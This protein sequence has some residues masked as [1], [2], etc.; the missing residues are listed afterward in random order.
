VNTKVHTIVLRACGLSREQVLAI[1][2]NTSPQITRVGNTS[3]QEERKDEVRSDEGDG[4]GGKKK[5]L[6]WREEKRLGFRAACLR[7]WLLDAARVQGMRYPRPLSP[8]PNDTA[9]SVVPDCG[10]RNVN[11]SF[12]LVASHDPNSR[13]TGVGFSYG[14]D[15]DRS[16]VEPQLWSSVMALG[17]VVAS[18]ES[19]MPLPRGMRNTNHIAGNESASDHRGWHTKRPSEGLEMNDKMR[20]DGGTLRQESLD[21][22]AVETDEAQSPIRQTSLA[23]RGRASKT[24]RRSASK[25]TLSP[26]TRSR[27]SCDRGIKETSISETRASLKRYHS[28]ESLL[29]AG[30]EDGE[31]RHDVFENQ[32]G[33]PVRSRKSETDISV[34]LG[35]PSRHEGGKGEDGSP[36]QIVAGDDARAEGQDQRARGQTIHALCGGDNTL[37]RA[38]DLE[39]AAEEGRRLGLLA[40]ATCLDMDKKEA[41]LSRES[42][43]LRQ[44]REDFGERTQADVSSLEVLLANARDLRKAAGDSVRRLEPIAR[45]ARN[46]ERAVEVELR[47]QQK[48]TETTTYSFVD[49]VELE[50]DLQER[51]DHAE[52]MKNE[53]RGAR[54]GLEAAERRIDE[55]EAEE[56]GLRS[57]LS[58][59]DTMFR[60]TTADISSAM[61]VVVAK[62]NALRRTE[63]T[64]V[65][66]AS[67]LR[68]LAEIARDE[69]TLRAVVP[70]GSD[71]RDLDLQ[72]AEAVHITSETAREVEETRLRRD[73]A[74]VAL[75]KARLNLSG[76]D[77]MGHGIV[78]PGSN[79]AATRARTAPSVRSTADNTRLH[80]N[81]SYDDLS[82]SSEQAP[83]VTEGAPGLRGDV[84]R[85]G[86]SVHIPNVTGDGG[87]DPNGGGAKNGDGRQE[88]ARRA[89]AE[90]GETQSG[91]WEEGAGTEGVISLHADEAMVGADPTS[92]ATGDK[93]PNDKI[94]TNA[95]AH[96]KSPMEAEKVQRLS[97]AYS[98]ATQEYM[99]AVARRESPHVKRALALIRDHGDII[100]LKKKSTPEADIHRD[101]LVQ[102]RPRSKRRPRGETPLLGVQLND[103]IALGAEIAMLRGSGEE[104]E[105][106]NRILPEIDDRFLTVGQRLR[107]L[108]DARDS[109]QREKDRAHMKYSRQVKRNLRERKRFVLAEKRAG[110]IAKTMDTK[111][112]VEA[113]K[114]RGYETE[115]SEQLDQLR[116]VYVEGIQPEIRVRLHATSR[117]TNSRNKHRER[118]DTVEVGEI[119]ARRQQLTSS[120]RVTPYS[121]SPF[122]RLNVRHAATV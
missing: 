29:S 84:C 105:E 104:D 69:E 59:Y 95:F 60:K 6:P 61:A 75:E 91:R 83:A 18:C 48:K 93:I 38:A 24:Q 111:Q 34:L 37:I 120:K 14:E 89:S 63:K 114:E 74:A 112:L 51:A 109:L 58:V 9:A 103:G 65:G 33:P 117:W 44:Q 121:P 94:S 97:E 49:R 31:P 102:G 81:L 16:L 28:S 13:R 78:L 5:Q 26:P 8:D 25:P 66:L 122:T 101:K 108:R 32:S 12:A 86:P 80:G 15:H 10:G 88:H 100:Q 68:K 96:T 118:T 47:G 27:E 43:S 36:G 87:I 67:K 99:N 50:R 64:V 77:D 70:A 82:S 46:S 40:A 20:S 41:A 35:A 11:D 92:E 54:G 22:S 76:R 57:R 55:L 56:R 98:E 73:E 2:A 52:G 110:R 90:R 3:R 107:H 62:R 19:G 45:A 39:A 85:D 79:E 30:S 72:V 17:R 7:D 116:R 115:G 4:G 42:Q 119:V 21:T 71:R 53:L 113:L 23:E 1:Q 106:G